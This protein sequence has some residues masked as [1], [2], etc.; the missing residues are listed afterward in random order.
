M[1]TLVLFD[2]LI[3]LGLFQRILIEPDWF[4]FDLRAFLAVNDNK[5]IISIFFCLK[6]LEFIKVMNSSRNCLLQT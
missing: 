5:S 6:I 1:N 3:I 4:K 2:H